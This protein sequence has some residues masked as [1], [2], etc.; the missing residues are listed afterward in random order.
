MSRSEQKG[1]DLYGHITEEKD[2][3]PSKSPGIFFA[4]ERL[5]LSIDEL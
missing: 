2:S 3:I 1:E 4:S 5:K